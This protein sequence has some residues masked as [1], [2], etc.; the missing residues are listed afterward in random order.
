[1][2][3]PVVPDPRGQP[4]AAP[5]I[6]RS[7]WILLQRILF[8]LVATVIVRRAWV[9]DDA[10]ITFRTIDNFIHGYGLRYNIDERVQVFT[11]PLW[12]TLVTGFYALTREPYYTCLA[13]G[14]C[15]SLAVAAL[16]G[17]RL[18]TTPFAGALGLLALVASRAFTDYSTSGLENPLAHLLLALFLLIW[19]RENDPTPESTGEAR[20]LV[21]LAALLG[22]TRLD[23]LLL[24]LPAVAILAFARPRSLTLRAA[25]IGSL[26]LVLWESFSLIY[27]GGLV[28]NT[29]GA[30]LRTG[31]PPMELFG[32]GIEYLVN[33]SRLDP[34]T[35]AVIAAALALC[36]MKG[37]VRAR[38][39]AAGLVLHLVYVTAV[40]GDFMSGRFL[41]APFLVAVVLLIR[42]PHSRRGAWATA[43]GIVLV[44]LALL[45]ANTVRLAR[46]PQAELARARDNPALDEYGIADERRVYE[47]ATSLRHAP[48]QGVWPN[49]RAAEQAAAAK[50]DW[51]SQSWLP[52]LQG[53]GLADPLEVTPDE[54][55]AHPT[56]RPLTPVVARGSIGCFG[57]YLGPEIHLLD[58]QALADPLLARLP[59][60]DRDPMLPVLTPRLASRK[61]RI[62][63]YP[64]R[65]PLGYFETLVTG[66][67]R[68]HDRD[69][70]AY[71][72]VLALI[73]RGDLWDRRRLA[74]I[75]K[76]NT[77]SYDRL[78][79]AIRAASTRGGNGQAAA[80]SSMVIQAKSSC[81]ADRTTSP[82]GAVLR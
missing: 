30:K 33:S 18:A 17:F 79:A 81:S 72:D 48:R 66:E 78:L 25:L 76:M 10:Y 32:R 34:V 14:I 15:L 31:I 67:N 75:W 71:Y 11:H 9:C 64:R 4:A 21:L 56:D 63:H 40:G 62:G 45:V 51:I 55:A 60:M 23:L 43:A 65:I 26:P 2:P 37:G 58:F 5:F 69:L 80:N 7:P 36:G 47:A 49:P 22:T 50:A 53:F 27:Y 38:A 8:L 77:G 70:A 39:L 24:V 57:F 44:V 54:L 82:D 19:L 28:P 61:W 73:T 68:I 42:L 3:T 16:V 12:M 35:L 41:T 1:M 20:R 52:S 59:V 29:A 46:M 74:A 6:R 13:L